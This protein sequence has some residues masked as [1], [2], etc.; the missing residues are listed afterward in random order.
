[1]CVRNMCEIF[2]NAVRE[3]DGSRN[4]GALAQS[5]GKL[6]GLGE[7][8]PPTGIRREFF[9]REK[10]PKPDLLPG[11]NECLKAAKEFGL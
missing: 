3:N 6:S 7:K 1:M 8:P 9:A 4:D 10:M 2:W 11:P 5:K